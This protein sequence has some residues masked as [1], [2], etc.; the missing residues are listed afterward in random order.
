M[1]KSIDKHLIIEHTFIISFFFFANLLQ[2][3]FFLDKGIVEFSVSITELVV[4]DEQFEPFGQSR[5]RT[6]VF[7]QR[8]HHLR[9]LDDE[10]RIEAL[11]FKELANQFVNQS[12][13]CAGIRAIYLVLLT[14]L[15][16]ELF[17]FL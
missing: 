5:F 9:M 10:S 14:L 7:G 17:S 6:M 11:T 3:E 1:F 13:R 12:D 4:L 15:I 16:V 8:R 2:K